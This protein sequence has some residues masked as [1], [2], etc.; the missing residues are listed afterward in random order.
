MRSWSSGA[1]DLEAVND[2]P[3]ISEKFGLVFVVLE[4]R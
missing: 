2:V 3:D 1:V 4:F